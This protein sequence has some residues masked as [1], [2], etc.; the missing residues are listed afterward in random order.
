M[1]LNKVF[2]LG[3]L[4]NDPEVRSLPSGQAVSSFSLAT[5]RVWNDKDGNKQ[6]ASEFHNIVLFGRLAD[7]AN[8]YLNKGK[9]CLIVGRI[10][11]R[12]WDGKDG[13]KHY[14]TE[15]VGEELQLGPKTSSESGSSS[16]SGSYKKPVKKEEKEEV[17]A[18]DEGEVDVE[19]IP[20]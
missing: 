4:T 1:N 14:R 6:E 20:F 3:R 8:Q 5:N 12:S 19:D 18:E 15:I 7:V 10:Q 2:I 16:M 13:Q 11:N 17:E 9:T